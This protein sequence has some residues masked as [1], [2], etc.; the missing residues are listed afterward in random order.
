MDKEKE[1]RYE[2]VKAQLD[3]IWN[4]IGQENSSF[5]GIGALAIAIIA[6]LTLNDNFVSFGIIEGKVL[7]T[8]LFVLIIVIIWTHFYVLN[9]GKKKAIKIIN[10]LA[11]V[12]V[13]A[14]G[15]GYVVYKNHQEGKSK[16]AV[17][18]TQVA[19]QTQTAPQSTPTKSTPTPVAVKTAVAGDAKAACGTDANCLISA[20]VQC[21]TATGTIVRSGMP[22][23]F[24]PEL[25]VSV[26]NTFSMKKSSGTC[27]VNQHTAITGAALTADGKA[28]LLAKGMTAT[29]ID[30]QVKVMRDAMVKEGIIDSTCKSDNSTVVSYFTDLKNNYNADT[31][32]SATFGSSTTTTTTSTG[33]KIVCTS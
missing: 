13:L 8:I 16:Q 32:S 31:N 15:G 22:Y 11:E 33:Q 26:K 29:E 27:V 6:L 10:E 21:Q 12:A 1:E 4:I 14:V 20:A 25:L 18:N 30:D 23:P 9:S 28:Q 7:L 17:E 2:R 5:V 24:F 19:T 3:I